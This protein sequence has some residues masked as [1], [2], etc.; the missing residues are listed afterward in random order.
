M[1]CEESSVAE[2]I[3]RPALLPRERRLRNEGLIGDYDAFP[4]VTYSRLGVI[5]ARVSCFVSISR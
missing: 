3:G 2:R 1:D 5:R 4:A